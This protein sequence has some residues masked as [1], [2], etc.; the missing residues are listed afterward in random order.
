MLEVFLVTLMG[1]MDKHLAN[2]QLNGS[3]K[4]SRTF[5]KVFFLLEQDRVSSVF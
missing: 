2:W 5:Y 3:L 1:F 4:C